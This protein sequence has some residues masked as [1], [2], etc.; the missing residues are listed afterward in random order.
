MNLIT[1]LIASIGFAAAALNITSPQF[2]LKI[3]SQSRTSQFNGK[4][5]S[6][7]LMPPAT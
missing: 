2:Y 1:L 4:A 7:P 6:L 3:D 5:Q